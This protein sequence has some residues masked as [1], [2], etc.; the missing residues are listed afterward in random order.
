MRGNASVFYLW[1]VVAAMLG[2]VVAVNAQDAGQT[3]SL[4]VVDQLTV[5]GLVTITEVVSPTP[6]WVAIYAMRDNTPGSLVGI[7]PVQAGANANI[8]VAIDALRATPMLVAQLHVDNG[9]PN[10]FEFGRIAGA[11]A[12]VAGVQSIFNITALRVFAQQVDD[13]SATI[14]SVISSRP[15]WIAVHADNNGQPGAV[16]GSAAVEAGTNP[17]IV[18]E[19]SGGGVSPVLWA[20]LHVDD[21]AVGTFEY[22][23]QSGLDAILAIN[24]IIAQSPFVTSNTPVVQTTAGF[25]LAFDENAPPELIVNDQAVGVAGINSTVIVE[26]VVAA[27]LGWLSGWN[28]LDDHPNEELGAASVPAGESIN[29]TVTL[30]APP[31]QLT[32]QIWLVLHHD[33]GNSGIYEYLVI[34]G[35]DLPVVVNGRIIAEP[36]TVGSPLAPTPGQYIPPTEE[37]TEEAT[38]APTEESTAEPTAESTAEPTAES[39]AESTVEPTSEATE[40]PTAEATEPTGGNDTTGNDTTGNDTTGNDTTGNDTT[41]NDTTGN[42]TTGNDTTGNDTT[43]NDTTGNDTTAQ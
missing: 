13:D 21:G 14:A 43:G 38:E 39:T 16:L 2:L 24:G 31:E 27:S 30:N 42:D 41:G 37:P 29:R 17:E 5:D 19:L 40:T 11:D 4:A 8:R 3:A 6:G 1:V 36:I 32:E 25:P 20:V 33:D 7:A 34:P 9:Q 18:V 26:R 15:Y 10:Q 35:V 12:P 28:D 23:A 22:D